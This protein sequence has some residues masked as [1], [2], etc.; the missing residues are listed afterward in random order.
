MKV[1]LLVH[2]LVVGGAEAMIAQLARHL[3][4]GGDAVEIGCLGELG[5]IGEE[6]RAEGL[7]VVVHARRPG[8]DATLP[9]RLA[10]CVRAESFDVVHAHQR[11]ALFYGLLAGWL[12]AAPFVYTE[13]GPLFG[14]AP[15]RGQWLFNRLLRWRVGRITAVSRD[16][17][18]RLAAHEGFAGR[19][20]EVVPNGVDPEPW[21]AAAADGR[22]AARARCGLPRQAAILG[23]VGRLHAVKNQQLL[24]HV[25]AQ[26]RRRIPHAV[27]VLV[28]DGPERESLAALAGQLG[29][30]GA[31]HFLGE[32]RDVA[33]ILPAFDVYCLTSLS[34]GIP[35]TL[36]EAMAARVPVVA[37]AAGGVP[38]VVRPEREA[39]LVGS[40]PRDGAQRH[41]SPGA[42]DA[43]EFAA[44]A[45]RLL[46]DPALRQRLTEHASARVRASFAI[47][48]V[49]RRY[50]QLLVDA[51]R[52][53]TR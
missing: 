47:D 5:A 22:D 2:G 33:H 51:T 9:W 30:A 40:A 1:L 21:A 29:V 10:R 37:V 53:P 44:A 6:L 23:S 3:R 4:A 27:L 49:C 14:P 31:V 24:V 13:H 36:L 52:G 18:R 43:A 42:P 15:S 12:H 17:A 16:A 34:E 26:L 7:R 45:Q 41:P 11:T 8:F 32:R 38:E 28:G 20:I 46:G 50:R 19:A 35:L 48:A 25:I 39:L